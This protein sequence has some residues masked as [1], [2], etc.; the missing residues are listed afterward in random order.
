MAKKIKTEGD[1]TAAP[2][3]KKPRKV[4]TPRPVFDIQ[5]AVD[6]NG[7]S[8][9]NE[10]GKLR[11]YPANYEFGKFAPLKKD[12]FVNSAGRLMYKSHLAENRAERLMKRAENF[13]KQAQTA[14]AAGGDLKAA[15]KFDRL[16]SAADTMQKF[17]DELRADGASE[18]QLAVYVKQIAAMR[19]I[20]SGQA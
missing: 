6:A 14:A 2:K 19:A 12:Q 18:E 3:E 20:E 11:E 1:G 4:K 16:A 7:N 8:V 15:K 5:T 13:R 17:V 10:E 9:V